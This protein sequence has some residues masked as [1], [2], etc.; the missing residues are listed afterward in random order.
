MVYCLVNR[1]GYIEGFVQDRS[2]S[3]A[4][5]LEPLQSR[6]RPSIW[7]THVQVILCFY[8]HN[9]HCQFNMFCH[10]LYTYPPTIQMKG[11]KP[12]RV[13]ISLW[14][15]YDPC[16]ECTPLFKSNRNLFCNVKWWYLFSKYQFENFPVRWRGLLHLLWKIS[17]VYVTTSRLCG[18][19][20]LVRFEKRA[21]KTLQHV[22]RYGDMLYDIINTH[23]W[24]FCYNWHEL[25]SS[26]KLLDFSSIYCFLFK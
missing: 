11:L 2:N 18:H 12:Q 5:A 15:L 13:Y 24:I 17:W 25:Y 20:S 7:P 8:P 10:W 14:S 19:W 26:N 4:N 6:T 1:L 22:H 3:I 16:R 9:T 21:V 23:E